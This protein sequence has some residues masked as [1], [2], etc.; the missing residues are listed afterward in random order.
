MIKA[1]TPIMAKGTIKSR[2]VRS[3]YSYRPM[4]L[5][6]ANA[7]IHLANSAGCKF[8]GPRDIQLMD[9]LIS[10]AKKGVASSKSNIAPYA[11]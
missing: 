10:C 2:Q 6:I 5:A 3:L 7:T 1:G 9:P 8:T 11:I 4:Y